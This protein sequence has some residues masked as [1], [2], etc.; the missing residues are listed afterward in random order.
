MSQAETLPEGSPAA[1]EPPSPPP[2]YVNRELSL[3]R[4]QH[5]VFEEARDPQNPLL[6][7]VKFLAIVASNLDEL[8]MIRVAGLKQQLAAG[9]AEPTAD[10]LTPAQQ[11]AEIR[12]EALALGRAMSD[13]LHNELVPQLAQAGIQLLDYPALTEKEAAQARAYFEE[14]VF[15]VLTPLAFDP[16]RPFPH[17]SNLSLNL[18]VLVA[19]PD[20]EER[21]A[22]IKVPDTLPRLVPVSRGSAML[23]MDGATPHHQGFVWL[24]QLIAANAE[25]LFP[26]IKVLEVHPFHV[27]RSAE[28]ALQEMEAADLRETV[29]QSVRDRRFGSVVRLEVTPSTPARLRELLADNLE[30]GPH[31][32]YAVDPPLALSGLS[33][34]GGVDRPDLKF[35][36]FVP[37]TPPR[38]QGLEDEDLF[39]AIRRQDVL[40][41]HPFDSFD[42]VVELLRQAARDPNVV[43]IKQT[44]Y[45]VGRNSPVVEALLEAS[46]NKKQVA[47]LVEVKA[48]FDEESNLGWARALEGEGVHVIY[49]LLGFKTHSKIALVIRREGGRLVRYVHLSTGNYNAVTAQLYTDLGLF[50]A[51]ER[52]GEDATELFNYLTGYSR[53][54]DWR[55]LLVAPVNLRERLTALIQREIGHARAGREARLIFKMNALVDREMID[56]LVAASRAG[57]RVD[58]LVRGICCLRPGVPGVSERIRVVSIVGRFLEHSRA[59]WFQNGGQEEVYLGS[60]DLMPRNLDRRVEV[61]FPVIDPGLVRQVR[62]GILE[63]YLRDNARARQMRPDASYERLAPAPGEPRVD[64]QAA[65]IAARTLRTAPP[66][67]ATAA[68]RRPLAAAVPLTLPPRT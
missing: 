58:L 43:A 15:P 50:T 61:L 28:I 55:R 22:R 19:G 32:I 60:A 5:R 14:M 2:L 52:I 30:I 62:D 12:R 35:P 39:A 47:V 42:P 65:L 10:G 48:R 36:S 37:G 1:P 45:R 11:L 26:G 68:T 31:D 66:D 21:F 16:G 4:F 24:E 49:G 56:L 54:H 13:C 8:F 59:Y 63:T 18:A 40:L 7:R 20:G 3:L 34:L 46:Q 67:P 29:Q 9:F 27:T 53:Q 51:D 57:V 64:S 38:L 41:H 25:R 44:L 6:E 17:I 33:A 23:K